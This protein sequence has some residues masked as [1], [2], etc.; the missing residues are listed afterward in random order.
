[1]IERILITCVL[2]ISSLSLS[3]C[4]GDR[5]ANSNSQETEP[6]ASSPQANNDANSWSPEKVEK[7][8]VG[9]LL[10]RAR[11]KQFPA[12]HSYCSMDISLGNAM[13]IARLRA[14][15]IRHEDDSRYILAPI[16]QNCVCPGMCV[17]AVLDQ[18]AQPPNN[19]GLIA[20]SSSDA[21]ERYGW[22]AKD[23]NLTN[24]DLHFS[25]STPVVSIGKPGTDEYRDC[26]ILWDKSSG[27]YSCIS[28]SKPLQT[29]SKPV[30]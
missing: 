19:F 29:E 23:L 4:S 5:L 2:A 22:V 11:N 18:K 20:F 26:W 15:W 8:S 17:V 13:R 10:A 30:A 24:A 27:Q 6:M 7:F 25:S 21:P 12:S 1:M 14:L 9:R 28:Y 3:S 16:R